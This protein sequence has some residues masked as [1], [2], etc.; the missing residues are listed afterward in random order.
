MFAIYVV[1]IRLVCVSQII[2]F[3]FFSSR[4]RHTR[5]WRDW[6]SDV[7]SS[8]LN[9]E[10]RRRNLR[11][12][13]QFPTG[14][15][16]PGAAIRDGAR[17]KRTHTHHPSLACRQEHVSRVGAAAFSKGMGGADAEAQTAVAGSWQPH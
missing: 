7:C 11:F 6:S 1:Q 5:Y 10:K 14:W 13:T 3:F 15:H 2:C 17:A 9:D 4:R 16:T 12:F 8:D